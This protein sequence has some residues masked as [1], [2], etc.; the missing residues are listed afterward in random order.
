M[1]LVLL[2]SGILLCLNLRAEIRTD[3][4][5]SEQTCSLQVSS[6]HLLEQSSYLVLSSMCEYAPLQAATLVHTLM[7]FS[8]L[9]SYATV[10]IPTLHYL[11]CPWPAGAVLGR[12]ST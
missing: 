2:A 3:K 5:K 9:A 11:Q 8:T 1:S 12:S 7:I 6:L 4:A 10:S